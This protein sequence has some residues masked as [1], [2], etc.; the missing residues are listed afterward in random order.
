MHCLIR[1]SLYSSLLLSACDTNTPLPPLVMHQEDA[2][3]I[4]N[5]DVSSLHLGRLPS[6]E[7]FSL[8]IP[9]G[10]LGFQIVTAVHPRPNEHHVGVLR[11]VTP[12]G[13]VVRENFAPV[14]SQFVFG[15]DYE[16][17]TAVVPQNQALAT[18]NAVPA[19]DWRITVVSNEPLLEGESLDV[20]VYLQKGSAG[21]F[22]GGV[23]NL[24]VYVPDGLILGTRT[25]PHSVTAETIADDEYTRSLL[26]N[27]FS[28]LRVSFGLDAGTTT[29]RAFPSS[30][31]EIT[32]ELEL[33]DAAAATD[34]AVGDVVRVVLTNWLDVFGSGGSAIAITT[35]VPTTGPQGGTQSSAII[36]QVTTDFSASVAGR[37]LVH[38]LGHS[39]GLFHTTELDGEHFDLF[40]D[41]PECFEI[42]TR[43]GSCPDV[44][45]VMFPISQGTTSFRVSAMQLA[46]VHGSPI[47]QAYLP[48]APR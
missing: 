1:A 39:V 34:D 30:F 43:T 21:D 20:D 5:T 44:L 14:G 23:I 33:T 9:E 6:G 4:V 41:T 36:M 2:G 40:T 7:P 47:Y 26:Q 42:Q 28:S 15:T 48:T 3:R 35:G 38:E 18:G 32:N 19:G 10:V 45:N 25:A 27:F 31:G 17:A 22:D 8:N 37:A 24:E 16:V 46:V 12:T 29:F 11:I 13:E